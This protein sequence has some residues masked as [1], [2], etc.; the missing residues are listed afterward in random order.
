MNKK[1]ISQLVAGS[2]LSILSFGTLATEGGGLGIYPDGLENFMSGA[3]PPQGVHVLMYGGNAHYDSIR[4]NKGDK[5]PVPGF[6]VNVNVLAPRLIWVTDQ[7]ILGGDLAFHTIVPLLDVTAKA[8]GK[9]R[10]ESWARRCNV[11]TCTGL[12]PFGRFT[13]CGWVRCL[14]TDRKIQ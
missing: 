11:W 1:I 2:C 14:C 10:D 7:K 12:P 13:L 9:K 8:A 5:I 4:D 3:L 6:S